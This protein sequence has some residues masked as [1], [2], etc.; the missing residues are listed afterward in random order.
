MTESGGINVMIPGKHHAD[1]CKACF[2]GSVGILLPY[3]DMK[4]S[5]SF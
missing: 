2:P 4:V 5:M 1:K 3:S